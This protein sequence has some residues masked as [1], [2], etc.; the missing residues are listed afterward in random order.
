[1]D[2]Q[3][4]S[5][6]EEGLAHL[7]AE[8]NTVAAVSIKLPPLWLADA[9][10]WFA[11]VEAQFATRHITNSPTRFDYVVAA[12]SHEFATEI[13]DLILNPLEQDAYTFY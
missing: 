1:M 5:P 4:K 10:I 11:Q 13:H 12:L 7:P 3:I 6:K 2:P 8:C 9:L